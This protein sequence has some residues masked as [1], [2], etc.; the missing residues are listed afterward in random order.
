MCMRCMRVLAFLRALCVVRARNAKCP[1]DEAR[2]EGVERVGIGGVNHWK[3]RRAGKHGEILE[4]KCDY[5]VPLFA[6]LINS[7]FLVRK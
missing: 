7:L 1:T 3:R 5:R 4:V 2:A 6:K